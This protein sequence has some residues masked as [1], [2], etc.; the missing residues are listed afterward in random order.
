MRT[1]KVYDHRFPL[2]KEMGTAQET[3]MF[4]ESLRTTRK[5]PSK[6]FIILGQNWT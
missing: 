3:S 1:V 6:E 4:S 5:S 2:K